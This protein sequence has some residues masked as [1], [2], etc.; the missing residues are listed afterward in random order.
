M[1][2]MV[3]IRSIK[4]FFNE[5]C[6]EGI[7]KKNLSREV[8]SEQIQDAFRR[9]VFGQLMFKFNVADVNDIPADA[10]AKETYERIIKNSRRKY[11]SLRRLCQN[12]VET[13]DM[14]PVVL[15]IFPDEEEEFESAA[16]SVLTPVESESSEEG[17]CEE[18]GSEETAC[19]LAE[20]YSDEDLGGTEE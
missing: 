5:F 2:E 13:K 6:V 4:E 8:V 20:G 7:G 11:V 14:L 9:E 3:H 1:S 18:S 10:N 12:Y 19:G 15:K 16:D 17:N